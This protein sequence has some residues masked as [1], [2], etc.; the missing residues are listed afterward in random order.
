MLFV[1]LGVVTVVVIVVIVLLLP[2]SLFTH[3]AVWLTLYNHKHYY[4]PNGP[5]VAAG[6]VCIEQ[7]QRFLFRESK[8]SHP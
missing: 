5:N 8:N 1:S 3:F 2:S 6:S 4:V 7:S